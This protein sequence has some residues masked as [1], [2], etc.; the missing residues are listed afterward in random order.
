MAK[1]LGQVNDLRTL[2]LWLVPPRL[3]Q[4]NSHK[5]VTHF[6]RKFT[7]VN[8][9]EGHRVLLVLPEEV[10]FIFQFLL[11]VILAEELTA[12]VLGS[13]LPS[14]DVHTFMKH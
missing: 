6:R 12:F 5:L 1:V 2:D 11:I 3:I 13:F 4:I 8:R 9:A 10:E 14:I 7:I